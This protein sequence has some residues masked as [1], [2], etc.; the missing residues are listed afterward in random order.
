MLADVLHFL[1]VVLVVTL[2][3][4][5][6]FI[7]LRIVISMMPNGNPLKMILA[8]FAHRVG[9][10]VGLMMLDPVATTVPVAGEVWDLATMI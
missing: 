8:A 7:V 9:A 1:E 6:L 3:L 2:A 4:I 5:A 10:T